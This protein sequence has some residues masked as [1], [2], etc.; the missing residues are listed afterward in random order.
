MAGRSCWYATQKRTAA[1]L[2]ELMQLWNVLLGDMS[3]VG[4]RPQVLREVELYT[5][6]ERRLLT[7]SPGITDL[8]S[9][10]FADEGARRDL[11]AI[12]HPAVYRAIEA[13]MRA[14]EKAGDALVVV[15]I[16]LLYESGHA[17]DFDKVI[18][19]ACS[20][21]TQLRRLAARGLNETRA[22]QVLAAQCA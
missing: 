13:G 8:S 16:T 4:P 5:P 1:K 2:D 18:V 22:R 6:V 19:T 10:V 11:E 17:H 14:F 15:E 9:I 7:V 12:V 3:L 20:E 21:E